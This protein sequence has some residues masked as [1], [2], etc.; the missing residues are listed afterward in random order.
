MSDVIKLKLPTKPEYVSLARLSASSICT[1][2]GFNIEDIEDIKVSLGEACNNAVIHSKSDKEFDVN[3][4]IHK[5]RL[6]VEVIDYGKGFNVED[7]KEP[8][9]KNLKGSG[10]GIYLI[11]SLMDDFEINK[12]D[13]GMKLKFLKYIG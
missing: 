1:N 9:L 5:D 12:T 6:E 3:F 8:D 13:D 2:M 4:Y 10:L 11:K 7:Y